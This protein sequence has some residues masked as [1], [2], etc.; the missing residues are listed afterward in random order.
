M[1]NENEELNISIHALAISVGAATL[2]G[3]LEMILIASEM[4]A[5]KTQ[6]INYLMI[7]Y[8]GR[9]GWVPF[10]H[11]FKEFRDVSGTKNSDKKD[12]G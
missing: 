9:F 4:S 3:C 7:C 6:L 2:H 5:A 12:K 11:K 8:N 10:V 1:G